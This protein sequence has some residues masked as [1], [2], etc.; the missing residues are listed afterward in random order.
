MVRGSNCC[1]SPFQSFS[2]PFSSSFF[3]KFF[4]FGILLFVVQNLVFGLLPF[5]FLFGLILGGWGWERRMALVVF[6]EGGGGTSCPV[7]V[8]SAW[9]WFCLCFL[10]Q[11]IM[12]Y[13][14]VY[15][16]IYNFESNLSVFVA[17]VLM[18][19][20]AV[21]S[22]HFLLFFSSP[23]T[24]LIFLITELFL[25]I[26]FADSVFCSCCTFLWFYVNHWMREILH[27]LV[28]N[29]TVL[30]VWKPTSPMII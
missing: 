17:P 7:F 16:I 5:S 2:L 24:D 6:E 1:V 12:Y 3:I 22:R 13:I 18:T 27:T 28:W 23:G 20:V 8:V 26:A 4:A 11:C 30:R 9:F 10:C 14:V 25:V 15:C 19:F 29:H 21:L